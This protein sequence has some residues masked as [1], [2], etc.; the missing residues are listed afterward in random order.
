[1]WLS[2]AAVSG[3]SAPVLYH[4]TELSTSHYQLKSAHKAAGGKSM[5]G[6]HSTGKEATIL[7]G[8]IIQRKVCTFL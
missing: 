2:P 6:K 1:M 3:L 8:V 4:V 7:R 5:L